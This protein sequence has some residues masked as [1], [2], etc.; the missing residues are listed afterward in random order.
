MT[1]TVHSCSVPTA[2]PFEEIPVSRSII[3]WIYKLLVLSKQIDAN[4]WLWHVSENE[5]VVVLASCALYYFTL[6]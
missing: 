2:D 4:D 3:R 5:L 6:L 1:L